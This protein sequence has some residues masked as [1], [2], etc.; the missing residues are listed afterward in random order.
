MSGLNAMSSSIQ[1]SDRPMHATRKPL[2]GSNRSRRVAIELAEAEPR[3][4]SSAEMRRCLP[5]IRVAGSV[6]Q[7]SEP[8]SGSPA[9]FT[10]ETKDAV[11]PAGLCSQCPGR[12]VLAPPHSGPCPRRH[13]FVM[14]QSAVGRRRGDAVISRLLRVNIRF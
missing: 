3:V 5:A 4:T 14:R 6:S 12:A 9:R 13:S 2:A 7:E 11:R 8:D 1:A 10:R